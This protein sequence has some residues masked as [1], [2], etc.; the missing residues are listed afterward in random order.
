MRW[1]NGLRLELYGGRWNYRMIT[2]AL[3]IWVGVAISMPSSYFVLLGI[4]AL[5]KVVLF[6]YNVAKTVYEK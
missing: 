3:L 6:G 4:G 5:I 2:Y 1:S